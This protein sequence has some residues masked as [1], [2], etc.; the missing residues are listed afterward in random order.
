MGLT[1]RLAFLQMK[2]ARKKDFENDKRKA[3]LEAGDALQ[4]LY[5]ALLDISDGRKD[6]KDID[7]GAYRAAHAATRHAMLKLKRFGFEQNKFI[8]PFDSLRD[9]ASTYVYEGDR[10]RS[11][12]DL[13]E[14]NTKRRAFDLTLSNFVV[15]LASEEAKKKQSGDSSQTAQTEPPASPTSALQS[16]SAD[17]SDA[18]V[19]SA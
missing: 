19:S 7:L 16:S 14:F 11:H 4:T 3:A 18:D 13:S 15:Q 1:A 12:P 5:D 8:K 10:D 2:E 9:T 6:K 17:R